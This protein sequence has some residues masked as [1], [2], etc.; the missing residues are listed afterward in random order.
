M[1]V[2]Y[3]QRKTKE[4]NTIRVFVKDK[5]SDYNPIFKHV[6]D[7]SDWTEFQDIINKDADDYFESTVTAAVLDELLSDGLRFQGVGF[8]VTEVHLIP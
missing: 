1:G 5:G 3:F 7:W 6:G 2:N 8:T 4:G